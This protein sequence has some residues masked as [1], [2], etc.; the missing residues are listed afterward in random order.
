[1]TSGLQ[2]N[3]NVVYD[4]PPGM[5]MMNTTKEWKRY[6]QLSLSIL[7]QFG[8]GVKSTMESRILAELEFIREYLLKQNGRSFNPREL[9]YLST[10]NVLTSILFGQRRDY[11]LGITELGHQTKLLFD[12]FD[13]DLEV[14]PFLRFLPF[15]RNKLRQNI[16]AEKTLEQIF[17][18]KVEEI[19]SDSANDC[20]VSR[21]LKHEGPDYDAEQL[22]F[23]LRDLVA[24]GTDSTVNTLLWTLVAL[25]NNPRVQNRLRAEIDALIPRDR[26]PSMTD[27]PK[28]P[29]VDATCVEIM[30][31]KTLA[32]LALPHMTTSDTSVGGY[33]V[34]A[35]T[36][37]I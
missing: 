26:L 8:F 22:R 10:T 25:A 13:T 4:V 3:T 9:V 20:F 11:N 29:Y 2:Q 6:H 18:V 1:M 19:Q 12:S 5:S 37:V 33:F 16:A 7:K 34:P 23:A 24:A 27:Q 35:G 21:Y 36:K 14:A 31:W 30:R 28:L 32:P 15:H 17:R